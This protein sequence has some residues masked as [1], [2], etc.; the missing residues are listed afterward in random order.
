MGARV[1]KELTL[2][3]RQ[4]IQELL[5]ADVSISEIARQVNVAR[6]TIYTELQK[7][8]EGHYDAEAAHSSVRT[9]RRLTFEDRQKIQDLLEI[10]IPIPEIAD[11]VKVSRSTIYRELSRCSPDK[12]NALEA[13]CSVCG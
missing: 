9:Y 12:Y 7:C 10:S 13:Q 11:E 6:S 5:K 4:K 3:D 2:K 1:Y 8:P